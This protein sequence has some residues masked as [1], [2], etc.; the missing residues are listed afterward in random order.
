MNIHTHTHVYTGAILCMIDLLPG[1]NLEPSYLSLLQGENGGPLL[2]QGA[3]NESQES[4][5]QELIKR[6]LE[7]DNVLPDKA[8]VEEKGDFNKN[9]SAGLLKHFP[10]EDVDVPI[11]CDSDENE[12]EDFE[13][14]ERENRDLELDCTP[15]RIEIEWEGDYV[16]MP[17]S[18]AK[19]VGKR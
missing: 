15:S 10:C 2:E 18:D 6:T 12:I 5:D 4:V 8:V 3:K 11:P 9:A 16:R 17:V 19:K 7:E 13:L 1:V 14:G